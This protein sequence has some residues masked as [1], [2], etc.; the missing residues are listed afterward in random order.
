MTKIQSFARVPFNPQPNQKTLDQWREA[1]EH[2][3]GRP[4]A[5]R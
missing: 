4:P 1:A 2:Q 3:A 5:S